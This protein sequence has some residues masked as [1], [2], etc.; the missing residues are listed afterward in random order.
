MSA[1]PFLSA[2]DLAV[3]PCLSLAFTSAPAFSSNLTLSSAPYAPPEAASIR[4]VRPSRFRASTS[5]CLSKSNLTVSELGYPLP[6]E[7]MSSAVLPS[8]SLA[9]IF[10]P[11]SNSN[12][13]FSVRPQP[14]AAI[15]AVVPSFDLASISAPCS[16]SSFNESDVAGEKAMFDLP[17]WLSKRGDDQFEVAAITVA[18]L[19]RGVER[20]S[21]AHRTA[22]ETY[23]RTLL[24][25]LPIAPYT[26]QTAYHH[27]RIRAQLESAGKM[28]GPYDLIVAATAIER[29]S[30]LA[31]FNKRHFAGIAGL[32]IV[33]PK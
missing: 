8:L 29:E 25:L 22:R 15:R 20:A 3:F 27:A 13:A 5:A 4:A 2:R 31:T 1:C 10:A 23:L 7:A 24:D 26:E 12:F 32:K 9:S 30:D 17:S 19:W 11:L 33:E 21:A 16:K 6:L 18:E 28:I 14:A